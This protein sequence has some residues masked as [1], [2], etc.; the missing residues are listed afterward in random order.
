MPFTDP[1]L[2][3][4]L[5]A[6][7]Q[8]PMVDIATRPAQT[9]P[10]ASLPVRVLAFLGLSS[11]AALMLAVSF[12]TSGQSSEGFRIGAAAA[13]VVT[14]GGAGIIALRRTRSAGEPRT[15]RLGIC[16]IGFFLLYYGATSVAWIGGSQSGPSSIVPVES[17]PGALAVCFFALAAWLVGYAIGVPRLV[18]RGVSTTVNWALPF[19][20]TRL[21]TRNFALV[22]YGIGMTSRVVQILLGSYLYLSDPTAAISSPSPVTQVLSQGSQLARYGLIL[23][24]LDRYVLT[25][26]FRSTV[27]FRSL[28]AVEIAFALISGVKGEL[29]FTLIGVAVVAVWG[30]RRIPR[31]AIAG[32]IAAVLLLLPVNAAYRKIVRFSGAT[33]TGTA[34][35]QLFPTAVADVATSGDIPGLVTEELGRAIGRYRQIDSVGLIMAKTPSLIPYRSR[36]D[37]VLSVAATFVP[38]AV[39]P[40]KPVLDTGYAFGRE[41]Y[42]IPEGAVTA[43][44]VTLPGDFYRHGG[45]LPVVIGFILLGMVCVLVERTMLPNRDI[46]RIVLYLPVCILLLGLED[47]AVSLAANLAHTFPVLLIVTRLAFAD[48]WAKLGLGSMSSRTMR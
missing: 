42:L 41:Y 32:A 37:L 39:W 43:S 23:A 8:V 16:W 7:T 6:C 3:S 15:L 48:P 24:A 26:S 17:I 21:R 38:R 40:G 29:V 14:L 13:S 45:L 1:C 20:S 12:A 11:I 2:P 46:R 31:S 35:I 25:R 36:S 34:A 10:Q 27:I 22:L 33:I 30:G 18:M 5:P 44:A 4:Q 9:R 19:N 28:L 47:G